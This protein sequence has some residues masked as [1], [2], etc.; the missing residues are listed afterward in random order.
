[1][2]KEKKLFNEICYVALMNSVLNG[3]AAME[4]EISPDYIA[5]KSNARDN[6][7]YFWRT[8]HRLVREQVKNYCDKWDLPLEQWLND[9]KVEESISGKQMTEQE[10]IQLIDGIID[11]WEE[12]TCCLSYTDRNHPAFSL[13]KK[14]ARRTPEEMI[15][16]ITTILKRM[17][18]EVTL[19]YTIFYDLVPNARQPEITEEMMGKIQEQTDVWVKWGYEKGYLNE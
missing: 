15:I 10:K 4:Y 11:A 2:D 6:V 19:F 8:L 3:N 13:I 12:D 7:G 18:K 5:E 16:V 1:M 14:I 9:L 17:E